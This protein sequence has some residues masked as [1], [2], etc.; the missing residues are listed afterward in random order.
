MN[1]E[2][3][4]LIEAV[5]GSTVRIAE[6]GGG[7]SLQSRLMGMGLRPGTTVEVHR[8]DSSGPVVLAVD[9]GRLVIGRGM[10]ARI[11]VRHV[12]DKG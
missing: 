6:I 4:Q 12:D 2:L 5:K 1:K 11:T 8:N 9:N 3:M 10:A 7:H